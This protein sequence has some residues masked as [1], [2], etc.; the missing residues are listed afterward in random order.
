MLRTSRSSNLCPRARAAQQLTGSHSQEKRAGC[1]VCNDQPLP[2]QH[3]VGSIRGAVI[4][5]PRLVLR[6]NRKARLTS[7][8]EASRVSAHTT[9]QASRGV[10]PDL[11]T[12]HFSS[13]ILESSLASQPQCSHL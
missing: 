3:T 6:G 7:H 11:D 13:E 10:N 2:H 1:L 4:C 8:K 9:I 5:F 12:G